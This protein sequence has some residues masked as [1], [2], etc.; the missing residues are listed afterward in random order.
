MKKTLFFLISAVCL[1]LI[2]GFLA[3]AQITLPNPD[4][5]SPSETIYIKSSP[6]NP[7]P[8]QNTTIKLE[9]YLTDLNRAKIT[10]LVNGKIERSGTGMTSFSTAAGP[11]GSTVTVT[12][13]ITTAEGKQYQRTVSLQP[14]DVDLII[15]GQS[16]TPAFYK[17]KSLYLY[18]GDVGIIAIPNF[19][20]NKTRIDPKKLIYTW[21]SNDTVLGNV[22]GY[23]KDSIVIYGNVISRPT[24]VSVTVTSED[25]AISGYKTINL[26]PQMPKTLLY[27]DSPLLGTLFNKSLSGS[28][29]LV[30]DEVRIR[31]VPYYFSGEFPHDS[32]SI[33]YAWQM[34]SDTAN[35]RGNSIVL[36]KAPGLSGNSSV[37]VKTT[38]T[39][40]ILQ[41]TS[42]NVTVNYQS[43]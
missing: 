34:N 17:G 38:S 20:N 26:S 41:F 36:R 5:L 16:Y 15:E 18:Q 10:W 42:A 11:S 37:S 6:E 28:F 32:T 35:S 1:S 39:S 31:A 2:G 23:G 30:G 21:K 29:K 9:S 3:H 43:R 7:S 25:G 27:E 12:A 13:A 19:I 33:S 22:S 14:A 24:A 8:G 4:Q 40:K